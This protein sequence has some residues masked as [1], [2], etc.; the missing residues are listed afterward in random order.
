MQIAGVFTSLDWDNTAAALLQKFYRRFILELRKCP[1]VMQFKTQ[2]HNPQV[3]ARWS[4][5]EGHR[6]H[7][8]RGRLAKAFQRNDAWCIGATANDI[9]AKRLGTFYC[10]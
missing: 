2:K 8:Y 9:F 6:R 3:E 4:W 7:D 5:P 10:T 1:I